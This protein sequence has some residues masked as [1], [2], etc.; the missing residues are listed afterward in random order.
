MKIYPVFLP[1]AGCPHRCLFCAQERSSGQTAVPSV[2]TVDGWLEKTLPLSGD[3]EIAFYGGTFSSLPLPL[4]DAFLSLASAFVAKGRVAGIRISTRPDALGDDCL[5]R[6]KSRGVTTV[7]VGCQSFDDKVLARSGR[8]HTSSESISA[9]QRCLSAGLQVGVQLM[10]GLPAGDA[11]EA[12]ASLRQALDLQPDFLRIYPTVVIAGTPLAELWKSGDYHPWALDE[13]VEVCAD[14]LS[15]CHAAGV[16]VIRLGLQHDRQLI[17]NL[18]AGPYHPA[19]GQLVRSRLWRRALLQAVTH[20]HDLL[21]NPCDLSDA[22]GHHAENRD[23]LRANW[24]A[25]RLKADNNVGRGLVS[26]AGQYTSFIELSAQGGQ[27]A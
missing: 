6:L 9:V 5:L 26:I 18:L 16:L 19:F 12:I 3:G 20:S 15:L 8:G 22:L 25:A 11:A 17:E 21:V 23:W 27:H 7:E 2:P 1:H 13:A 14:M 4:Q 10:P 24:P